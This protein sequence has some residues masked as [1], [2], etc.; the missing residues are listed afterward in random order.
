V[1]EVIVCDP[2]KN[3]LLLAG[4]KAERSDAH[5]LA[6]LLRAGVVTAVSHGERS[7][8]TRKDLVRSY[9]CLVRDGTRVRNR[10]KALYRARA[11]PCPGEEVYRAAGREHGCSS[12]PSPVLAI[13]L[14]ICIKS[15]TAVPACGMKRARR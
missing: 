1:A 15:L 6:H 4:H 7:T 3:H 5:K 10:L 11:I 2:R 13:E 12:S 9:E 14:R 8:Q